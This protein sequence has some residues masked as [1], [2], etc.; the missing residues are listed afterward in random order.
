MKLPNTLNVYTKELRSYIRYNPSR[1]WFVLIVCSVIALIAIVGWNMAL[2]QNV[3]NGGTI[4]APPISKKASNT[5][6]SSLEALQAVIN[7]RATEETKYT[8]GEYH[9]TDPSQ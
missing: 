8:T 3:I 9:F 5:D 6:V 7:A 2:F 4:G 1:D